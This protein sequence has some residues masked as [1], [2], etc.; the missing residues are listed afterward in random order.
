MPHSTASKNLQI[1]GKSMNLAVD[2]GMGSPGTKTIGH[3]LRNT[4]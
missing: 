2:P 4:Q 1:Y 3:R